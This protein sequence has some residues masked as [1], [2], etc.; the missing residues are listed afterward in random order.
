MLYEPAAGT[1]KIA[2]PEAFGSVNE[3]K[4]ASSPLKLPLMV[5]TAFGIALLVATSIA[6]TDYLPMAFHLKS[7]IVTYALSATVILPSVTLKSTEFEA[8]NLDVGT[9]AVASG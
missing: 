2:V 5:N 3:A 9:S 6:L 1:G 4:V 7:G 8:P